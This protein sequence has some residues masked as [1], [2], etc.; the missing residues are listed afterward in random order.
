[1][2]PTLFLL[3]T[4]G[5]SAPLAG[6]QQS[7]QHLASLETSSLI[8]GS[9]VTFRLRSTEIGQP[10]RILIGS[11][12]VRP[13][14]APHGLILVDTTP[15]FTFQGVIGANGLFEVTAQLPAPLGIPTG[16]PVSLQGG[17][18][19]TT[20]AAVLSDRLRVIAN[21]Q[22]SA[23]LVDR[24]ATLPASSF[25]ES[26]EMIAVDLDRDGDRD[27]VLS[28]FGGIRFYMNV[29]GTLVDESATRLPSLENET[30]FAVLNADFNQD[31]HQDLLL[32]GRIDAFDQALP[33]VIY[34]N[35]GNGLFSNTI[36]RFEF[37]LTLDAQAVPA[38][39]DIDSD[40]D[41]DVL[42][43]DGGSHSGG[44]GPQTMALFVN[45]GGL[46]GG[47]LGDYLEDPTFAASSFNTI[48]EA[49]AGVD[50]GD[51]DNDGD[52]DLVIARATSAKNQLLLNDG[53]GFFT[54]AS[55]QLPDFFDKS[56]DVELVDLN[57]D[58]YLDLIV[59]NSHYGINPADA[60]DV[61]YNK[62][63]ASPGVFEDAGTRFPDTYDEDL[64]IRLFSLTADV[65]SDGDI[66]VIILP[67][68]F[69]GSVV[70]FVGQPVLFINQGGAQGGV[71]GEF[72]KDLNFFRSG[73]VPLNTFVSG[74]GALFDLDN[75]GDLEFYVGNQGGIVN[76]LNSGDFLLENVIL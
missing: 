51:V 50:F 13:L 63:A 17:V 24:S 33:A 44:L 5:F 10:A 69:F 47:L 9:S 23:T 59:A 8:P 36:G 75:D 42:L 25:A 55:H 26:G 38:I 37:P 45:Q 58:G 18:L 19:S 34:Y 57:Q 35:D 32:A 7:N 15:G 27:L 21:T 31:G 71:V 12:T 16:F 62:G 67:H 41:L 3:L 46:Q 65:D 64:I 53:A 60:G 2:K 11:A 72:L 4:L 66:D 61:L 68:E 29:A 6:Q 76:P 56:S 28:S 74:G 20:G 52:L 70:P 30:A 49:A 14:V 54:D 22:N 48:T 1:M 73:G 43:T 40:G 39:G